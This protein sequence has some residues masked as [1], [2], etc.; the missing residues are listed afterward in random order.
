MNTT[1][2]PQP[3]TEATTTA[4]TGFVSLENEVI[5]LR[6]QVRDFGQLVQH[7]AAKIDW[8]TRMMFGAK[9]ERRPV[10]QDLGAAEQQN[11]LT[12]PVTAVATDS[13]ATG[14]D[15]TQA[16]AEQQ[17]AGTHAGELSAAQKRN[18]KKGRGADGKQKAKNG[19]G[20]RPVNRS[21]RPV[22]RKPPMTPILT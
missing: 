9:S 4:G 14:P 22:D 8:L 2:A 15:A 16:A 13:D 5:S 6:A 21:L 3:Q 12:M 7:Q 20:R 10:A 1:S 17:E 11:F 18:A 19:G